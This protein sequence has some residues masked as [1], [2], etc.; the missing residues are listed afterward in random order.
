MRRLSWLP[1]QKRTASLK[2]DV[3]V[4]LKMVHKMQKFSCYADCAEAPRIIIHLR[5]K[6]VEVMP[7]KS[8]KGAI[9][10]K[11]SI[12]R[13]YCNKLF[14]IE[15]GIADLSP[16]ERQFKVLNWKNRFLRPFGAGLNHNFIYKA[17]CY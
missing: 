11:A 4:N 3:F 7:T 15:D 2:M 8:T 14:K 9:R 13:A 12:G 6:F 16:K 5:R 10:T 1:S 17:P